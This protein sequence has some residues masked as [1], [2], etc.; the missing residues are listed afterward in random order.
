VEITYGIN[1]TPITGLIDTGSECSLIRSSVAQQLNLNIVKSHPR[2]LKSFAGAAISEGKEITAYAVSIDSVTAIIGL[3]LVPDSLCPTDILIGNT[4]LS[5]P[6]V[7]FYKNGSDIYFHTCSNLYSINS[8][9]MMQPITCLSDIKISCN[10]ETE[11]R[12]FELL[13]KYRNCLATRLHEIGKTTHT[14]MQIQLTTTNPVSHNPYRLPAHQRQKL[15]TMIAE[16]LENNIIRKSTSPYA[17]PI[18][19]IPKPDG[20][21]RL[22]VDYRKLNSIT[23]K[24]KFPLPLIEDQIDKLVNFKYFTLLDLFSGY[25]QIPMA[26]DSIAKT[27]FITPDG[28][29][30][31]LRMSFGL[32]NAP[33]VF[34]RMMSDIL[35]ELPPGTAIAYLDDILIPSQTIDEGFAKLEMVLQLLQKYTLTLQPSKCKFFLPE[36]KYLGREISAAGVRPDRYKV[37]AI[38]QLKT[39]TT[40]KELRQF[41]GLSNYFRKYIYKYF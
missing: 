34:Q 18:V 31:Y 41:L 16:L 23:V 6:H 17:S 40:K 4:F 24:E 36:I 12:L 22:C 26:A 27:A 3:I 20:T 28:K 33:S 8:V 30:E 15:A 32:C 13:A 5:Q 2:F 21:L 7:F 10:K 35:N 29:Y 25:Y 14:E 37:D 19:L 9:Q 39:P 38:T 11:P 1:S